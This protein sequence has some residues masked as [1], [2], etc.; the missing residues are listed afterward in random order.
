M[1]NKP[2]FSDMYALQAWQSMLCYAGPSLSQQRSWRLC[3]QCGSMR[4]FRGPTTLRSPWAC[5][6]TLSL[7][8][9]A[10]VLHRCAT[11][12]LQPV[13]LGRICC[14]KQALYLQPALSSA[15]AWL[16]GCMCCLGCSYNA[17]IHPQPAT[18]MQT[19]RSG[20][21]NNT[22]SRVVCHIVTC[23]VQ[24]CGR[25]SHPMKPALPS[26]GLLLGMQAPVMMVHIITVTQQLTVR[27]IV[28][29]ERLQS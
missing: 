24:V 7:M 21:T 27:C 29:C 26:L 22:L 5:C 18:A 15:C 28:A 2:K 8:Q 4:I 16:N 17:W 25:L 23:D 13:G 14:P 6:K 9:D 19:T 11:A 1:C 20:H 10:L 3:L 12:V